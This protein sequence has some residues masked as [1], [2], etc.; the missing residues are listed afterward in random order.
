MLGIDDPWIATAYVGNIVAVI[1]CIIYGALNWNKGA[2]NEAAEIDEEQK[3]EAQENE[4]DES[5]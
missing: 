4:L 2:E 1:V 5:F 3:W